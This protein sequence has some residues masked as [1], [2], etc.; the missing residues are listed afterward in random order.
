M[1][2]APWH[3]AR[4]ILLKKDALEQAMKENVVNTYT[5]LLSDGSVGQVT[6]ANA[7]KIGYEMTVA[8]SD[9]SGNPIMATGVVKKIL[10]EKL[11]RRSQNPV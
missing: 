9:E 5:V 6:S 2:Q 7:P 1:W 4:E 10:E 3:W 8:L 11:G